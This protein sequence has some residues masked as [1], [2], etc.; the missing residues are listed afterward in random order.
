MNKKRMQNIIFMGSAFGKNNSHFMYWNNTS[1]TL[2]ENALI[3]MYIWVATHT[4]PTCMRIVHCSTNKGTL[5]PKQYYFKTKI[6]VRVFLGK[7]DIIPMHE[8]KLFSSKCTPYEND[9]FYILFSSIFCEMCMLHNITG[10]K[11]KIR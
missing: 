8:M 9:F 10:N 6:H 11:R 2:L 7:I 4:S 1:F 5:R 3:N